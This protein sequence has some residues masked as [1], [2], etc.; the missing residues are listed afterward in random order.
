MPI[1]AL[2]ERYEQLADNPESGIS[3]MYSSV[4]KVS[5]LLI[6]APDGRLEQ[7]RE[8]REQKGKKLLPRTF[9]VPEQ[10][11]RSSGIK[12]YFL[13]DKP[14]YMLGYIPEA[15]AGQGGKKL[16][17][18]R[19]KFEAAAELHHSVLSG[20]DDEGARAVLAFYEQWDVEQGHHHPELLRIQTDLDKGVDCNLTFQLHG[21]EGL[22]YERPPVRSAWI[23]YCE[24]RKTSSGITGQCLITGKLEEP[25]AQTHEIKIKGVRNAQSAGAALV[26]FNADSFLSY[27]KKQSLNAP[28]G[29]TASFAYTTALNHLLA[30]ENNR[31]D[32][33]GD[34]SVVY[35]AGTAPHSSEA[36][37]L[38]GA[39]FTRRD[40]EQAQEKSVTEATGDALE[41]FRSGQAVTGDAEGQREIPFYVLGLSPN[42]AR[43]SVRM[44]WQ[45]N[46]GRMAAHLEQHARDFEMTA[47][48]GRGWKTP[49]LYR[50]LEET[51]R[52]GGDGKKVG[53]PPPFG[54]SGEMF[55]SVVEGRQY[56]QSLY[57]AIINRIRADGIVNSLR[58][59]ILKGY[60]TRYARFSKNS[61]LMEVLS[62]S[63]NESTQNSAY[64][65]G[66]AFAVLER[67]QQEAAGGRK[68]LNATIKDRYF[69][70]AS[71]RPAAVFP[72]LFRLSQHHISK[73]EYGFKRDEEL[74]HILSGVQA[75]PR[76]LN[77]HEQGLFVLGYYHQK[78][79]FY[80]KQTENKITPETAITSTVGGIEEQ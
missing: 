33:L 21:D 64:R 26:S 56:P 67:A 4:G 14:D 73:A 46:F 80:S 70:A 1:R 49:T 66:R 20:C 38:F 18:T 44:F 16:A 29:K 7:V 51:R 57:M 6:L 27:G 50:I 19:R 24:S 17:D 63:L 72:V 41:R 15:E 30:S 40:T 25:I 55:R 78:E 75:F 34:M 61:V 32:G 77:N 36:E 68:K 62:V 47:G 8:V 69:S 9:V 2:Y 79:Q 45:G 59:A 23:D 43:I 13:S 22:I 3:A 39:F 74:Q 31:I 60:L 37:D 10:P 76:H 71:A 35:W 48:E 52:V 65:L 5:F 12:P 53:D 11:G 54:L 28:V 42:N 58:A